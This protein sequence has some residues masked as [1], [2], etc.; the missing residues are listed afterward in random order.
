MV[1]AMNKPGRYGASIP[2]ESLPG[3]DFPTGPDPYEVNG[4][5]DAEEAREIALGETALAGGAL[6]AALWLA[7][8]D[9]EVALAR[10]RLDAFE[11]SLREAETAAQVAQRFDGIV[12]FAGAADAAGLYGDVEVDQMEV[13]IGDNICH[14]STGELV[15]IVVGFILAIIPGIIF[16]FLLC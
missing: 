1:V 12:R 6:D 2:G 13:K 16:L 15:V 5:E 4:P 11:A 10:E 8:E 9:G 14:Y 3:V 7:P